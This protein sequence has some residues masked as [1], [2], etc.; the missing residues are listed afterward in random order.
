MDNELVVR[1]DGKAPRVKSNIKAKH[2]NKG[3]SLTK[4]K[5]QIGDQSKPRLRSGSGRSIDFNDD[6]ILSDDYDDSGPEVRPDGLKPRV[7]SNILAAAK[8]ARRKD[9]S[10]GGGKFKHSKKVLTTTTRRPFDLNRAIFE[11]TSKVRIIPYHCCWVYQRD[12]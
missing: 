12:P 1:P 3:H 9:F 2:A 10:G 6:I 7:K 8:T 4:H 11:A 5:V